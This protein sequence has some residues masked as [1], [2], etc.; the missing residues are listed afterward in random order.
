MKV[1]LVNHDT[2]NCG[3]Y[4]Y[5]LRLSQVLSKDDRY[6]FVYVESNNLEKVN[7]A[8]SI[9]VPDYIIYNWYPV[10]MGWLT[11]DTTYLYPGKHMI[12]HHDGGLP[13]EFNASFVMV[14]MT[15]DVES[16]IFSLPRVLFEFD[17]PDFI[18]NDI[19]TIGSFGFAL[20]HKGFPRLV[21]MVGEQFENARVNLHLTPAFYSAGNG[22]GLVND[23]SNL[24]R[25]EARSGIE[26][27]ITQH[28]AT[29]NEIVSMLSQ[30]DI[31]IF[32]YDHLQ[33][34]GI[35]SAVDYAVSAG[36]PFG[37]SHADIFRHV[38]NEYP[39]LDA[40]QHS[41]QSIIDLG[42]SPCDDFRKQWS[43]ENLKNKIYEIIKEIAE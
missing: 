43:N 31:N 35:S 40:E 5:G 2:E 20:P 10:T 34:S 6:D 7:S 27:N 33:Q 8:L 29:D 22:F 1:M 32:L 19:P 16:R 14:N 4:Q 24:C 9:E 13:H 21:R 23:I 15:E 41:I 28:F 11:A 36:R 37:V 25:Q 12:L 26:V 39:E 30:N 42:K 18:P 17:L 38:F 3:I